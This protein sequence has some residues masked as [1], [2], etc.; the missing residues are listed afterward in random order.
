MDTT[1]PILAL[2]QQRLLLEM[3]YAV[4][5][6]TFRRQTETMGI[7]RSVKR[8]DCWFPITVG[9]SYYN[10]LNQFVTEFSRSEDTDIEHNFEYGKPVCFFTSDINVQLKYFNFT[11]VVSFV[12]GDRM[13]V[14]VSDNGTVMELTNAKSL[15]VQLFFDETS[16]KLMFDAVDRVIKSRGNR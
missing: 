13:V 15:G 1:S 9:R 10:S 5:K 12:D 6:E 11:G 7:K 16:Y 4:E 3:E 2:Q 14:S 8:G